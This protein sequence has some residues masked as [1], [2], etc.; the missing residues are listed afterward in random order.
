M[1]APGPF[2]SDGRALE[3]RGQRAARGGAASSPWVNNAF[4]RRATKLAMGQN[5]ALCRRRLVHAHSELAQQLD[6]LAD[7]QGVSLFCEHNQ[8]HSNLQLDSDA[9]GH[10][11][12][13]VV[14][15][16]VLQRICLLGADLGRLRLIR[17]A[18]VGTVLR[19]KGCV[20]PG[21]VR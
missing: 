7:S 2:Q 11:E 5:G 15:H 6:A 4:R 21:S 9:T 8:S 16:L 10:R 1:H 3:V 12:D 17:L 14:A 18:V 19:W 13:G 20:V